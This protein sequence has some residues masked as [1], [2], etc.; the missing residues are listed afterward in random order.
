M[1]LAGRSC[2]PIDPKVPGEAGVKGCCDVVN[3]GVAV[4]AGRVFLGTFDGRLIALDANT[5]K[6]L[7]SEVTVDQSQNYTITGAPRLVNGKVIIGNGGAE[8]GLRGYVSAYD[9]DTGKLAWRFY[10]VPG[11]AGHRDGA[12]SDAILESLPGLPGGA[13]PTMSAAAVPCGIRWPMI[14]TGPAL[15]RCRQWLSVEP[16]DPFAGRR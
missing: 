1:R 9:M 11:K 7:W 16:V 10:T 6:E 3:R 13:S 5:G 8:F 15:H 2:G 12:A 4:E 14:R